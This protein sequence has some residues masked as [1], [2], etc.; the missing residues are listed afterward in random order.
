MFNQ[1]DRLQD[2]NNKQLTH[3][4]KSYDM[5]DTNISKNLKNSIYFD[6][7][8]KVAKKSTMNQKHGCVIVYKNKV[9][10]TACNTKIPAHKESIHAEVSAIIKLKNK[11]M[12]S[13]LPECELYV[14]RIGKSSMEYPLKYSKPCINCEN[15][16]KLNRIRAAYYSVNDESVFM[17]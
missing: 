8:S 15:Y 17:P 10:S 3:S 4:C 6:M 16:I 11:R 2:T 13:V 1:N 7:A 5:V 14:V 9:I 12:Q